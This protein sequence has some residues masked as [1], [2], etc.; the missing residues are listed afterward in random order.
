MN[1]EASKPQSSSSCSDIAS[2][3]CITLNLS[4]LNLNNHS[5]SLNQA[6]AMMLHV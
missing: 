5:E 3:I 6:Y 4:T 2:I 1:S